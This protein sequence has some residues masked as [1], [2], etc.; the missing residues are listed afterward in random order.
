MKRIEFKR[1]TP[2]AVGVSSNAVER[3]LDKLESGFTEPHGLMLMRDGK[4]FAEGWWS[5]FAAG[6]RHGLQS[7]TKTY[8]ATAVG[9]AYTEG[10]L[11]L[12]ERIIDIFREEAPA[13]PSENL[14]RLT[15]HDVLCMGCGMDEMPKPTGNWIRDFLAMPVNRVPGTCFMYNS[16]GSTLLGAIVKRLTGMGLQD[17]LTSR[18]FDKIGIDAGNLRWMYMPDGIEVGGGGL[19]ATTEDNLRLMKL[20]A[21]GGVWN[22]ER[23]LAADYVDRATRIQNDSSSEERV[24]PPA[25]DNFLGYGYQI[26]MYRPSGAY[27]AD[28]AMGQFSIVFPEKNMILSVTENASGAHSAQ[29][30]LDVLW[31]FL[32]EIGSETMLQED[33]AAAQRLFQRMRR[34][35]LPHPKYAPFH[36]KNEDVGDSEYLVTEGTLILDNPIGA[37]MTGKKPSPGISSFKFIFHSDSCTFHY[38][39]EGERNSLEVAVDGTRRFNRIFTAD[40]PCSIALASGA[41]ISRDTFELVVRWVE[42][43]FENKLLFRF[44]GNQADITYSTSGGFGPGQSEVKAVRG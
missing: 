23:I 21:D 3:L 8:A 41:W 37:M 1:V 29:K 2:E 5:P 15:V 11:R 28:G 39:Q 20:Y 35:S 26:W 4:I 27:R 42:T 7:L 31:E 9:I 25:R 34:L 19:F 32:S 14:K 38:S 17:Y 36:G 30:T 44:D 33:E 40:S 6:I 18:L 13:G 16:M 24:N 43:C 12:D 10:L 22:G